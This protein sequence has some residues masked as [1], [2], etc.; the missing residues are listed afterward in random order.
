MGYLA[1]GRR[2]RKGQGR[3]Q[4]EVGLA[5]GPKPRTSTE[6]GGDRRPDV[7]KQRVRLAGYG[8]IMI[9]GGQTKLLESPQDGGCYKHPGRRPGV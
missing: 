7:L 9:I 5:L 8:K 1:L 2:A 3:I 6:T 4:T